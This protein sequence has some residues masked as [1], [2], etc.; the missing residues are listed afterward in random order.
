MCN[1]DLIDKI[2]IETAYLKAMLKMLAT[3]FEDNGQKLDPLSYANIVYAINS[4][5]ENIENAINDK[6]NWGGK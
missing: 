6:S 1:L 4:H 5:V 3:H 2:N